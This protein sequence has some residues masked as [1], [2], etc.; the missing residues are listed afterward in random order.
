[1]AG[2][3]SEYATGSAVGTSVANT[4]ATVHAILDAAIV[5]HIA[6]VIDGQPFCT[7]NLILAR[8]DAAL[9]A[10]LLR[11]S[12]GT[13]TGERY[14]SMPDRHPSRCAGVGT[15]GV[16]PY[17]ELPVRYGVRPSATGP[18]FPI[19]RYSER[20]NRRTFS[21]VQ[22]AEEIYRSSNGDRWTLIR[23]TDSGRLIV[24]HEP[25]LSSGGR[26]TDTDVDEFLSVAGSGPEF[27]ALR[28]LLNRPTEPS[29]N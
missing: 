21:M 9:L 10:R 24:R 17:S 22:S 7:P 23:D 18:R 3:G 13:G 11:Q 27:A 29:A 19:T 14:A 28:R 2:S 20:Q 15:F 4:T 25:D 26:V 6:Y 5:C 12:N 16:P 8:G 1:V